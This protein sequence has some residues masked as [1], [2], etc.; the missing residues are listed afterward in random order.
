MR[1]QQS[2]EILRRVR[3]E[4]LRFS[5]HSLSKMATG[6]ANKL[7]LVPEC[8]HG[9]R[10]RCSQSWDILSTYQRTST[11]LTKF[12]WL[13]KHPAQFRLLRYLYIF[14]NSNKRKKH[15]S[16][17]LF[18]SSNSKSIE[19]VIVANNESANLSLEISIELASYEIRREKRVERK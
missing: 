10:Y 19:L 14:N 15:L 1:P 8:V 7:H 3:Y 12:L 16:S 5:I 17:F 4:S 6:F 11:V 9:F 13:S 18:K 2:L